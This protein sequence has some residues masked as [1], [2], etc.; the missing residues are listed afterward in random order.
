MPPLRRPAPRSR[1]C[2][3]GSIWRSSSTPLPLGLETPVGERGL[4]L[5]GGQRQRLALA[6]ALLAEPAILLMDDCITALDAETE[7]RVRAAVKDLLP[8]RTRLIVAHKLDSLRD[9]DWVIV[10]EAGR[11]VE[12]ASPK[13]LKDH[14]K[15]SLARAALR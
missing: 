5:S 3:N 12:Q 10:L 7:A 13:E 9:A 15:F 1:A 2:W 8:G 4:S 14:G 11:I 6:R